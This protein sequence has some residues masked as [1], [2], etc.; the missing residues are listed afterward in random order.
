MAAPE[1]KTR[2]DLEP[3]HSPNAPQ[4]ETHISQGRRGVLIK[5]EIAAPTGQVS[6]AL[7]PSPS[8]SPVPE[9]L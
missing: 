4:I 2:S 6:Q 9:A 7:G 8:K 5:L 3:I 1:F